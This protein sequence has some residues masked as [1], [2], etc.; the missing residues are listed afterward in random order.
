MNEKLFQYLWSNKLFNPV[1]LKTTEGEDVDV[2]H[3]GII[4]TNAGPD[5]LEG[6]V[7]IADKIWVGNIELHLKSSDWHKHGHAANP[8]YQNIILHVV[9]EDDEP[10]RG[11]VFPTLEMKHHF[12]EGVIERYHHLM[13]LQNPIACQRKIKEVPEIVWNHWLDSL[14]AERWEQ[15]LEEWKQY[16]EESG[17]DW[18]TLLYYRLAAN[19][20]FHTNRDAFLELTFSVPLDILVKHRKN[21]MQ[22]EAL[23]FVKSGLLTGK[24]QDEYMQSLEKEYHFLRRKYQLIPMV[25]HRWKFM[26]M[27]PSNFPTIRIAQFAMLIH[28]SLE[29]FAHMLEIKNA[30]DLF[31]LLD[32][33]A[34]PYWDNHYRFGEISEEVQVKYLGKDSIRNIL[35]NTVAPMQYLYAKLQGKT[36]LIENSVQLLQGIKAEKNNILNEWNNIGIKP[37]DA[38]QSQALLQLFNQYCNN[39][40][41][42]ECSVGNRLIR[43]A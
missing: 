24:L 27:R 26:R 28:K 18:R 25:A 4:N 9:Y 29:L 34:S 30:K 16:W 20:G 42:L 6:R 40:R 5:F 17:N 38:A 36:S 35:I 43:K 1:G 3:P 8:D 23:L 39:K 7:R 33:Y 14:L 11:I 13:N 12:N 21:I 41:C 19:F 22:I 10:I 15:R 2:I 32:I 31:P 37:K